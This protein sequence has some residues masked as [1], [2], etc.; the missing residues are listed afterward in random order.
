MS[1]KYDWKKG[2]TVWG[3]GGLKYPPPSRTKSAT[4]KSVRKDGWLTLNERVDGFRF[5]K[6]VN[7]ADAY[8][9][10]AAALRAGVGFAQDTARASLE[11]ADQI[12]LLLAQ[13]EP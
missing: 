13:V 6:F 7:P 9:T 3:L 12:R 5:K 10:E 4:V 8:P 11:R 1:D 2:D